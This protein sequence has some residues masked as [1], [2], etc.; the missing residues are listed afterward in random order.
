MALT[1]KDIDL[2]T[3]EQIEEKLYK[4]GNVYLYDTFGK[5]TDSTQDSSGD[6]STLNTSTEKA[7][8]TELGNLRSGNIPKLS[9]QT[10]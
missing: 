5:H 10:P 9:L 3:T 2:A 8:E 4:L 6:E 1:N 7:E